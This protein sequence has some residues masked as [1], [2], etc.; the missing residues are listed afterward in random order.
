MRGLRD[1]YNGFW[2][3]WL[4]LLTPSLQLQPLITEHKQWL[5]KTR[6]IPYW[7]TS[8]F[9]STVTNDERKISAHSLKNAD[10][11]NSSK[12]N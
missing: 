8:V 6:S 2:I 11:L 10:R 7:S 1:E 12:L 5:S 3:G 4:D 9:S